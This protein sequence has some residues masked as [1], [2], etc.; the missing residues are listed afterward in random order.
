MKETKGIEV[1]PH[2]HGMN[3]DDAMALYGSDKPD[4]SF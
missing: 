3:Y 4:T 2:S 1:T